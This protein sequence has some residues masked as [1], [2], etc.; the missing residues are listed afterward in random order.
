MVLLVGVATA[1]EVFTDADT[2]SSDTHAMVEKAV[3]EKP[4]VSPGDTDTV[5][6][7]KQKTETNQTK[8]IE[9]TTSNNLKKDTTVDS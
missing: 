2:P 3:Q 8:N 1:S 5:E 4:T 6:N 7:I 9:K